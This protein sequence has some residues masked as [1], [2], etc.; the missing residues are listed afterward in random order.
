MAI[1]ELSIRDTT[2]ATQYNSDIYCSPT[3]RLLLVGVGSY[4][5]SGFS[6]GE[7]ILGIRL[8]MP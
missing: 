3:E 1:M 5:V 7:T 6:V 4:H 2:D 8:S